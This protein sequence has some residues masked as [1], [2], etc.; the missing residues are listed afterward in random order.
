M[1]IILYKYCVLLLTKHVNIHKR[2]R[3]NNRM[4]EKLR[5]IIKEKRRKQSKEEQRKK[6]KEIKERLFDLKE[7]R[8]AKS[9]LFYVSY[10]GE[11]FTH[12]MIKEAM[13]NKRVVVPIS[14]KEDCSLSL[15]ELKDWDDLRTSSYGILEPEKNKTRQVSVDDVDLIIVPGVGFDIYG[16]RIGHGK[17]YY[18][19]LLEKTKNKTVIA[20]AFEFQIIE[21]IPT[22]EHD[23]PVDMIITEERIINCEKN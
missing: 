10:N 20:L 1:Y 23:V 6:T 13:Q 9:V 21:E 15:S 4:K 8:E 3:K 17:G 5:K 19:R 18:D 7:Y 16:N 11:V 22:K 12:D 2:I 14:N